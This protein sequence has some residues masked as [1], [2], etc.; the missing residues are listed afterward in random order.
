MRRIED[1]F[2]GWV[3]R[4][5]VLPAALPPCVPSYKGVHGVASDCLL[6]SRAPGLSPALAIDTRD[7]SRLLL[8]GAVAFLEEAGPEGYT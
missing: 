2:A 6:P 3:E 8:V 4:Q 7:S 5:L 1:L